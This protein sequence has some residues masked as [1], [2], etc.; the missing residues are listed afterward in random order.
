VENDYTEDSVVDSMFEPKVILS[1]FM[2]DMSRQEVEEFRIR[3]AKLAIFE[4][5]E[6]V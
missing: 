5:L 4:L 2:T 1:E 3:E 6:F